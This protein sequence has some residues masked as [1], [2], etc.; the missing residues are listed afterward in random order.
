MIVTT[1]SDI[2]L[3]TWPWAF[4][5]KPDGSIENAPES[6]RKSLAEYL[7]SEVKAV[8][9]S[10]NHKIVTQATHPSWDYSNSKGYAY[11]FDGSISEIPEPL[12]DE[13]RFKKGYSNGK[14]WHAA[15]SNLNIIVQSDFDIGKISYRATPGFKDTRQSDEFNGELIT[16]RG[17]LDRRE[18]EPGYI[19]VNGWYV[20]STERFALAKRIR[21]GRVFYPPEAPYSLADI[22]LVSNPNFD[23]GLI[24]EVVAAADKAS[25]DLLT[26]A[27]EMPETLRS[28]LNG[29]K[30]VVSAIRALKKREIT[31]SRSF[32]KRKARLKANHERNQKYLENLKGK[33][34]TRAKK[35]QIEWQQ[36]KASES[37]SKAWKST[38]KELADALADVWMNFRYNIMPNV[39]LLSDL[40]DLYDSYTADFRTTRKKDGFTHTLEREGWSSLELHVLN[41]CVIKRGL[42]PDL[43]FTSLTHAN[44]V[45]TAWELVPLSFVVDW[46]VNVGDLLT[47]SF[48]PN[49]STS[50]GSVFSTKM[51]FEGSVSNKETGQSC[52]YN[53]ETYRRRVIQ[54]DSMTGLSLNFDLSLYRQLDALALLWRPIRDSLLSSKR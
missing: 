24:T 11:L 37:F 53:I 1:V 51:T 45:T 6:V 50:Q 43:K 48:S 28:L 42:D 49:L 9:A 16:L 31:I 10:N 14:E 18:P 35:R 30:T 23:P 54:P 25:V 26:A 38:L 12:E 13:I 15:K 27:A 39:Y 34:K 2:Q 44:F 5:Y 3:E 8:Y 47:S 4:R 32:D 33:A 29:I 46:F 20:A 36:K 7:L 17:T 19:F 22:Q 52:H 41:R 21:S 40:H